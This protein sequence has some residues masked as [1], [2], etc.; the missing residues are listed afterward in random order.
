MGK[1]GKTEIM[2]A[3][4]AQ[5]AAKYKAADI[6]KAIGECLYNAIQG[7]E[8]INL[9]GIAKIKV[10]ERPARTGRNPR[11]GEPVQVPAKRA[12]KITVLQPGKEALGQ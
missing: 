5:G 11:T 8:E 3:I 2:A 6:H 12:L 10:V 4:T 7:G 9:F 1:V